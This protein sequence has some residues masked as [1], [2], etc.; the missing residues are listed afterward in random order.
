MVQNVF[1]G[2]RTSVIYAEETAFGT[3]ASPTGSDYLD[4]VT[5]FSS[6][7][8]NNSI[9]IHGIGEG[10]DA[11]NAVNG[12]LDISGSLE[13]NL[14][15]PAFL[16]Y[17]VG[18]TV[19]GAGTTADPYEIA[20][21]NVIG[22]GASD[23]PTLT[24]E[25]NSEGGTNDDSVK[26]DGVT[27]NTWTLTATQGEV[28][29]VSGDW[30]G[31]SAT[32]STSVQAY[33]RPTNRPF[34]FVDGAVNVGTDEAKVVSFTLTGENNVFTYRTLGSRL[35]NQPVA[36]VRRYNFTIAM[37]MDF[38]DAAGILSGIEARN[39]TYGGTAAADV[40]RNTPFPVS[41]ILQEGT[42]SGDRTVQF[43]LENCWFESF[44]Q[45]T[46]VEDGVIEVT[47]NGFG[48]AGLTDV[49]SKVPVRYWTEP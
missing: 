27:I 45:P 7:I 47:I 33:T 12:V 29:T 44:E 11:T 46:E 16:Q 18:G 32:S 31:R 22:Y 13:W 6:S 14:T 40:A 48:L 23:F 20:E 41:L 24:F 43:D 49:V 25:V 21:S 36:G 42:A 1:N 35:I 17:C 8:T 28:V 4:I 38:N 3:P 34:T 26:Y 10:R 30:I 19:S 39:L 9:R 37:K 2:L 5:N 15:D